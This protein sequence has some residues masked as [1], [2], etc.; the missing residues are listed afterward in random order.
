MAKRKSVSTV[1][2]QPK[3][4][5][6]LKLQVVLEYVR[7]PKRK[8]RICQENKIS[9]E[10]LDQ[11]HQEFVSRASQIFTEPPRTT[12]QVQSMNQS[13]KTLDS[14]KVEAPV[15]PSEP[16]WC[17][18]LNKDMYRSYHPPSSSD[19]PPSWLPKSYQKE[20]MTK[21]GLVFWDEEK[22]KIEDLSA[23]EA[24][25]LLEKLRKNDHWRK[26]GI[27]IT[28][29]VTYHK[30]PEEPKPK[31]SR[32]KAISQPEPVIEETKPQSEQIEE[33]LFRFKV[34]VGDEIVAFLEQHEAL[35]KEMAQ[36]D[37]KHKHEVLSQVYSMIFGWVHQDEEEKIDLTKRALPWVH[38]TES[39]SWV[40]DLPPNRGTVVSAKS[41]WFWRSCIERPN[42]FKDD[43]PLFV[44]LEEA[45]QWTEQELL[46][47]QKE[48]A[49]EKEKRAKAEVDAM[50]NPS[51]PRMD[52]TPY[53]IDPAALE[54]ER[55]TYCVRIDL[56]RMSDHYKTIE[57][58]FRKVMRY[59]EEFPGPLRVANELG[60]S[61]TTAS[62]TQPIGP[63]DGYNVIRST[64]VYYQAPIATA[65]AQ[66]LWDASGIQRLYK[67]GK[68]TQARY[69]IEEIE[70]HYCTW[71]GGL[72]D[73]EHPW[74]PQETREHHMSDWA[75][76]ETMAY[77]LDVDGFREWLHLSREL[78][79]D[80]KVLD[81]LHHRRAR[82]EHIPEPARAESE[83]WLRE[84]SL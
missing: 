1:E 11:W 22:H 37:E 18:R 29:L 28:R 53:R 35:L 17:M 83:Q 82:S 72:E 34:E 26:Q 27:V 33:E 21:R 74:R 44:D 14:P 49:E 70:T 76:E 24:L 79:D 13:I 31:R 75:M 20:W 56:T 41:N 77:A 45:M 48:D 68:V 43:S 47:I 8:K 71:L 84:H 40:C 42:R 38:N 61:E 67:A 81:I 66:Q 4:S 55:I 64:A 9:E 54:P 63:N 2:E 80:E 36:E 78:Y 25:A 32:K 16:T 51:K 19:K 23:S 73:P 12:S 30:L 62:V 69:G 6:E 58:S 59:A 39:H 46:K 57:M 65:Q 7:S 10:L 60:I 5:P 50:S 15:P 3:H 52:L